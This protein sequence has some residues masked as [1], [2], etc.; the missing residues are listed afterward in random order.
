MDLKSSTTN[1]F[2]CEIEVYVAEDPKSYM[3]TPYSPSEGAGTVI[4]PEKSN[5]AFE[6]EKVT[7]RNSLTQS[8]IVTKLRKVFLKTFRKKEKLLV[9]TVFSFLALLAEGQL[10]IVMALCPLCIC[11]SIRVCVRASVNSFFKKLLLRS[12]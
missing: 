11:P 2:M 4:L 5:K 9:V 8:Q 7:F 3:Q 6:F 12:C 1:V 10:A